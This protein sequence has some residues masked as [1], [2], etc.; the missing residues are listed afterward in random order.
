[1]LP[2]EKLERALESKIEESLEQLRDKKFRQFYELNLKFTNALLAD[3]IEVNLI[4]DLLTQVIHELEWIYQ[5]ARLRSFCVSDDLEENIAIYRE[6]A[7]LRNLTARYNLGLIEQVLKDI[8][9]NE[10]PEEITTFRLTKEQ[11][12]QITQ[13]TMQTLSPLLAIFNETYRDTCRFRFFGKIGRS[14]FGKKV[15]GNE[16]THLDQV[17]EYV[18][19]HQNGAA[20]KA[21]KKMTGPK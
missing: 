3:V 16:L 18:E 8:V 15:F 20:A 5:Y 12:T 6:F 1:M 7:P 4:K 21:W 11:L 9:G 19:T 10:L 2:E 17:E 13:S 14:L